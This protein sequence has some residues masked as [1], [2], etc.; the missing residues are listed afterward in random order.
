MSNI[1][2]GVPQGSVLGPLLFLIFIN[3][4]VVYLSDFIVKLFAD[5]TTIIKIGTDLTTLI[6]QFF[7]SIQK[8][9]TWCKYNRIDINWSKTKIMFISNKRNV[10]LPKVI[11]ICNH[12]VEV[13]DEFKLLGIII[14][15][16][17]TFLKHVAALRN[18][19]NKRVYSINRLFLLIP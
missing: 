5:D 7:N 1:R 17:L 14:D 4:I 3:D 18:S 16:K 12:E 10:E 8:L 11:D 19:I 6:N 13:V 15:N 2:L 9:S